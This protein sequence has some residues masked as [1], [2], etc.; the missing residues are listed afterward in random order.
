MDWFLYDNGLHHER[1][2]ELYI[3]SLISFRS[4][5]EQ[6]YAAIYSQ[7]PKMPFTIC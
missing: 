5:H 2:N 1:V 3:T 6:H 7:I 4:R